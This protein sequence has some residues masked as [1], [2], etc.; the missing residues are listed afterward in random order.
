MQLRWKHILVGLAV[1][2]VLLIFVACDNSTPR[3]AG[4]DSAAPGGSALPESRSY[5]VSDRRSDSLARNASSDGANTGEVGGI[6]GGTAPAPPPAADVPKK[7]LRTAKLDLIVHDSRQAVDELKKITLE[8]HGEIDHIAIA[9]DGS[10]MTAELQLRV[11]AEQLETALTRYKKVAIKVSTENVDAQDVTRQWVD[12]EARLKNLRQ[13]EQ[14]Y[15]DILRS[16]HSVKDVLDITEKL[17]EVRGEIE[18]ADAEHR[19]LAHNVAMSSVGITLRQEGA[20]EAQGVEWHPWRNA[21]SSWRGMKADLASWADSMVSFLLELPVIL[22][23]LVTIILIIV[24][25][26]KVIGFILRRFFK[27][28]RWPWQKAKPE[29]GRTGS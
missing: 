29:P 2:F 24:A 18:S 1:L 22:L 21:R 11:P 26:I 13:T 8:L 17:N 5:A 3:P 12:E 9:G 4:G 16:A 20:G 6:V 15:R 23:W 19:T 25:A 27:G 7:V 28:F 14:Q 10:S